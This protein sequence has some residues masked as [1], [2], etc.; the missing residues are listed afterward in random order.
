MEGTW[1]LCGMGERGLGWRE[2]GIV[3]QSLSMGKYYDSKLDMVR[4][5]FLG[6]MNIFKHFIMKSYIKRLPSFFYSIL[7][8]LIE[9]LKFLSYNVTN[10]LLNFNIH[11]NKN[12]HSSFVQWKKKTHYKFKLHHLTTFRCNFKNPTSSDKQIR[13]SITISILITLIE[14]IDL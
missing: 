1:T 12:S 7:T 2:K 3:N 4:K 9:A 10:F 6:E 13:T 14:S 8:T 5:M 11:F